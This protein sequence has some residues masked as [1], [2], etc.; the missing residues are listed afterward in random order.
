MRDGLFKIMQVIVEKITGRKCKKCAWNK[1]ML[2]SIG[3]IK[4]A[5]CVSSIYPKHFMKRGG[6]GE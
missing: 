1:G 5:E 4:N 6:K 3:V 2:C